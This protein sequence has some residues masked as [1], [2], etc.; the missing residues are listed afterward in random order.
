[1]HNGV[2]LFHIS[3]EDNE[4][5]ARMMLDAFWE[6]TNVVI[7]VLDAMAEMLGENVAVF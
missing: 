7:E 2:R 3:E 6:H 1:M 4:P 5:G